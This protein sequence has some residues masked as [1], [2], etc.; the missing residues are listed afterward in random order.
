MKK[1]FKCENTKPLE[2]FYKHKGM[3][4]GYLNKCKEC[5]KIDSRNT[6]NNRLEYYREYDRGRSYAPHK[7]RARKKYHKKYVESGM[8]SLHTKRYKANNPQK[9]LAHSRV[10][11]AIIKG[12]LVKPNKCSECNSESSYIAGHHTD[13]NKQLDVVWLCPQCHANK[14]RKY[15]QVEN[16]IN[17]I[18]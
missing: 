3:T 2:D 14:H 4:D 8:Q 11:C 17:S 18:P 16:K 1:C 7:I 6:R 9:C 10:S 13:Y 5:A 12:V 15:P